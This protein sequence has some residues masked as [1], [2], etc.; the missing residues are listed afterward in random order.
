MSITLRKPTFN[1]QYINIVDKLLASPMQER[2]V[3]LDPLAR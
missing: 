2:A 1:V 3:S